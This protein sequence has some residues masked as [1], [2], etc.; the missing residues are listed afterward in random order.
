MHI[1]SSSQL[2]L[3][4]HW[5]YLLVPCYDV[6]KYVTFHLFDSRTSTELFVG[7]LF[8]LQDICPMMLDCRKYDH[9]TPYILVAGTNVLASMLRFHQTAIDST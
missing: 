7:L 9:Y 8:F 1:L 2:Y 4:Y 3:P 5:S 6:S